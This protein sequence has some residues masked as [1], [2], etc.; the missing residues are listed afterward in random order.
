MKKYLIVLLLVASNA[1]AQAGTAS[2]QINWSAPTQRENGLALT[3]AEIGGYEIRYKLKAATVYNSVYLPNGAQQT[4]TLTA[5]PAGD[6]DIQI[7][8]VDTD[9]LY[10][11]F[12][13]IAYKLN[14][15]PPKQPNGVGIKRLS[16]DAAGEC[17]KIPSCKVVKGE[18]L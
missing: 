9:G 5:M 6:Y 10:S 13:A 16:I 3:L 4:F 7:A 14:M 12:V 8:A 18:T 1:F 15:S 2:M 17:L 11:T